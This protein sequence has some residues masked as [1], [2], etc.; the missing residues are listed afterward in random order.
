MIDPFFIWVAT[1]VLIVIR[2]VLGSWDALRTN[3][4]PAAI[5]I[6]WAG[7]L[8]LAAWFA[9]VLFWALVYE[10]WTGQ[11]VGALGHGTVVLL[12]GGIAYF[13]RA[14]RRR[15][16]ALII[17]ASIALLIDAVLILVS[18]SLR[19]PLTGPD[20]APVIGAVGLI[21]GLGLLL[22]T[23]SRVAVGA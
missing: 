5:W 15:L 22:W 12:C 4:E 14:D 1:V 3:R 8:M 13:L 9:Y 19:G 21:A 7:F 20:P 16:A 17:A 10:A 11:P 2:A 6:A 18:A 23:R